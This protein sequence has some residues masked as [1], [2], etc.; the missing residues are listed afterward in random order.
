M[1]ASGIPTTIVRCSFFAQNFSEHF[2]RDAVVEG[3]IAFPAGAAREPIVDADDIADVAVRALTEPGHEQHVYELTGPRLLSFTELAAVLSEAT[4]REI[5]YLPVTPD[6][7]AAGAI[8][9]GLPA[10]EA[11][12][13]AS[14]F[15]Y[16]F[17]GHNESVT[18]GVSDVLGRPATDFTVFAAEA[19]ATGVWSCESA[20]GGDP[21]TATDIVSV[22]AT[23]TVGLTAGVMFCLP[24]R[25]HARAPPAPT[26]VPSSVP[27]NTSIRRS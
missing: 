4:G 24:G 26:T 6:E 10:A 17:D 22:L 18:Q 16:I 11:S 12:M 5:E 2:L 9:A 20:R 1:L 23:V 8:E 21:M 13:L 27:S 3:L 25:H 14:L 7:Y 15:R 19:A